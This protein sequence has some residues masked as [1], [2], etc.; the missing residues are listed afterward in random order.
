MDTYTIYRIRDNNTGETYIGSTKSFKRRKVEHKYY[1][2]NCKSKKII[3]KN[4]YVCSALLQVK[5]NKETS[6]WL[7]RFAMKT[8]YN[9]INTKLPI[10]KKQKDYTCCCGKTFKVISEKGIETH[11]RSFKHKRYIT[12]RDLIAMAE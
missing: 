4:N 10:S 8:N 3:D 11:E 5:C 9:V 7:E 1:F 12:I 2:N 6:L